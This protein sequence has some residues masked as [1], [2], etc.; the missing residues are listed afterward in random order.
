MICIYKLITLITKNSG[1]T[2][3]LIQSTQKAILN[4]SFIVAALEDK[5]LTHFRYG[6]RKFH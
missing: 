1:F 3:I 6:H 2:Q 4:A 5:Y